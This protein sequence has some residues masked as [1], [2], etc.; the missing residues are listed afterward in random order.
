VT[1]T[2]T[3]FRKSRYE[4]LWKQSAD[5]LLR[6][7]Y[8]CTAML[9][10]CLSNEKCA[11]E[12]KSNIISKYLIADYLCLDFMARQ[13]WH[14]LRDHNECYSW[15][16][17]SPTVL[18]PRVII[19]LTFYIYYNF[20]KINYNYCSVFAKQWYKGKLASNEQNKNVS[21]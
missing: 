7:S 12:L 18:K 2:H 16:I 19:I 8:A 5:N 4:V 3:K 15:N 13:L 9:A 14:Q 20:F 10:S 21:L 17:I 1:L 11:W 6:L